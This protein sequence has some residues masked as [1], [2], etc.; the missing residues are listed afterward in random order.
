MTQ[1]VMMRTWI[2]AMEHGLRGLNGLEQGLEHDRVI[3]RTT[4]PSRQGA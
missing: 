3:A 1:M 4:T 2:R